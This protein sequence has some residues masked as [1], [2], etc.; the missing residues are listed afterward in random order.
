MQT[1]TEQKIVTN[2]NT[3]VN[4]EFVVSPSVLEGYKKVREGKNNNEYA[5]KFSNGQTL[6]TGDKV[7]VVARNIYPVRYDLSD[8]TTAYGQCFRVKVVRGTATF[9]CNV[10]IKYLHFTW[11]VTKPTESM[12]KEEKRNCFQSYTYDKGEE[13]SRAVC[14]VLGQ[15][16]PTEVIEALYEGK[17]QLDVVI[18]NVK[19]HDAWSDKD[20]DKDFPVFLI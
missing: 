17:N 5:L 12:T 11:C 10:P 13:L 19:Y 7:Q 15:L 2:Y 6:Q 9:E 18:R 14:N 4:G 20:V 16:T 3:V 1:E 8:G